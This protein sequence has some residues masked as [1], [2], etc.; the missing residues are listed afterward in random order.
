MAD[1]YD[2]INWRG[3]L[4]FSKS[5]FNPVD[6]IIFSQLSY[7]PMDGII[8]GPGE[9]GSVSIAELAV[10]YRKKL[11]SG[12]VKENEDIT[13][14]HAGD[15]LGAIS[16]VPRYKNCRIFAY[17]NIV[18]LSQEKQFAAYCT[19][20]DKKRSGREM[21][22]VYRGTDMSLVG[23]KEDFNMSYKT[24]IPSQKEAAEY[25]DE[26]AL[27]F[28]GPIIIAGHSKGG[29]LAVY[30]SACCSKKTQT[31]ICAI[32][33]NDAPGFHRQFIESRGYKSICGRIHGY[34]PQSSLIGMLFEHGETP[35]VVKSTAAGAMQHL[36]N[37]WEVTYNDLETAGE[38]TQQSILVDGIIRDWIE[39]IDEGHRQQF[40]E[41]IYRILVSTNAQTVFDLTADWK[42]T[43]VNII[44]NLRDLDIPTRNLIKKIIG[45]LFRTTG[46][47]LKKQ[48]SIQYPGTVPVIYRRSRGEKER[49]PGKH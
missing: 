42:K 23:F 11:D 2:Y 7:L 35:V 16:T 37:S 8:P 13:I 30:A 15:V 24:S 17:K 27:L 33:S 49:R 12:L 48:Y 25:L 36:L 44:A 21:L 43:A 31:R 28:N 9:R 10:R 26:M 46:N 19:I 41:A 40:I 1:L 38:L 20:I 5:P 3:D 22:V 18:D 6:N 29:N 34:I 47:I 39:D 4:D 14:L 32:Y 45:N